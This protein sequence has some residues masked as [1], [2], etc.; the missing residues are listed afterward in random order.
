MI[1]TIHQKVNRNFRIAFFKLMN[2]QSD[3][4]NAEMSMDG[5]GECGHFIDKAF[6]EAERYIRWK[7]GRRNIRDNESM[8]QNLKM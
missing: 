7:Q 8:M 5:S 3:G 6:A 4:Y 2:A 1:Q